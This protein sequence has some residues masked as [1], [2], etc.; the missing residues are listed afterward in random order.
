MPRIAASRVRALN[1]CDTVPG[2]YVL[3][4]MQQSQR[5]V[6]NHALEY[7]VDLANELGRPLVV[8]FGLMDDYPEANLRHYVFML[9]GLRETGQTLAKRGI[10]FVLRHGPPAR[11]ALEL[12]RR[13][14][15]VVCDR[16]YLRHQRAW[17][18]E[19][20]AEATCR[21]VQV[22]SDVIVPVEAASQKAEFA[23]RT[24]RP[25]IQRQL[26][27][28]LQA[29]IPAKVRHRADRLKLPPSLE[30]RDPEA[31]A[32]TL[33]LE[34]SISPV[35]RFFHGG[36]GAAEKLFRSF[37]AER[38]A[39]Y[40]EHR[41]QPQTNDVSHMSKYLHFGQISPTW[42]ALEAR[43]HSAEAGDNVATF[44]EELLVRRELSMNFVYFRDDY[45][46]YE[47]LPAW[48]RQTLS[49]HR[50]DP[51]PYLYTRAQLEAAET[52]DPYWNAAM[53]EMLHTGYMHNYMRMYWG[54]KILEWSATPE[55]GFA[56]ALAI[57]NRYFLDGR[58]ANSFAN[59]AW[60][61]GQHD[62]PWGERPIFG[63]VRY[64]NARGLERK[65]DIKAYVSKV[66]RLMGD[67]HGG[68][69]QRNKLR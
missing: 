38:L 2:D 11:V 16:G 21:V 18:R 54:K 23:A 30:L 3:Y 66:E 32:R 22:E 35:T 65:C 64:M 60:V 50:A 7:A 46:C 48:A 34:Q 69:Y 51:R 36:T 12:A 1:P 44:I 39:T 68:N 10:A 5:A 45:D 4:W 47:S 43:K 28:Y 62:R 6:G 53:R 29:L 15:A 27:E 25:R 31:L 42:L 57:N 20:A 37:L 49:E 26:A 55:E 14:S 33:K 9:E 63:K 17:R 52:H 19:V 59:I 58:D 41:N 24:L 13:A 40:T 8:G 61:F 67:F 56:A